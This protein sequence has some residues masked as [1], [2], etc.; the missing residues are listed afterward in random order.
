MQ[1]DICQLPAG[2]QP[3]LQLQSCLLSR[4][5]AIALGPV[6]YSLQGSV[7]ALPLLILSTA[8][9]SAEDEETEALLVGNHLP[10]AQQLNA[11]LRIEA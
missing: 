10:K 11:E 8:R 2:V 5:A 6:A 9:R 3:P 4:S 1:V 7:C